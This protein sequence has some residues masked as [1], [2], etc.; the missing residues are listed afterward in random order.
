ML[1]N[2]TSTADSEFHGTELNSIE[3]KI[4][5]FERQFQESW[6]QQLRAFQGN[7][8]GPETK[9]I[10]YKKKSETLRQAMEGE[11]RRLNQIIEV[12]QNRKAA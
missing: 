10:E 2:Y 9:F 11:I 8:R 3:E 6:P 7:F 5:D 4:L 1:T 12:L